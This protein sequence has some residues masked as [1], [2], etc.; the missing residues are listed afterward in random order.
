LA[1]LVALVPTRFKYGSAYRTV[2]AE[3]TQS[4]DDPAMAAREHL[5]RLRALVGKAHA[6]SPFYR[7]R[8]EDALGPAPD[9]S[10]LT[11]A[12]LARLPVLTK[13]ELVAAGEA[14]LTVP[15]EQLD[16]ARTSGSNT[17]QPFV[18][19]LDKD[20]SVR[21]IAFVHDVW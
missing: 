4:R 14:A 5:A 9:L 20:R 21:E 6:D 17:E 12:D 13:A 7:R 15:V 10:R 3:I 19:W 2:R 18:F 16:V 8:I 1:P 11:H